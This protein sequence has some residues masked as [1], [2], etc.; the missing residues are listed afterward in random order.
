MTEGC[1]P[2]WYEINVEGKSRGQKLT[3]LCL[4]VESRQYHWTMCGIGLAWI[5]VEASNITISL[6][7]ADGSQNA[8]HDIDQSK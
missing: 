7:V 3:S 8:M 5:K 6:R 1:A 2:V 4:Q